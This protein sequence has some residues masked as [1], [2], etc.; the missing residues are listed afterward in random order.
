MF[1]DCIGKEEH[2]FECFDGNGLLFCID[3]TEVD[4]WR[5]FFLLD[6]FDV[7]GE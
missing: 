4:I 2:S 5:Y 6:E 3:W 1:I 7:V